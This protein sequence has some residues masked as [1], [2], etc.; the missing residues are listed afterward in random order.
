MSERF[1]QSEEVRHDQG[2]APAEHHVG[3]AVA[4]N[5]VGETQRFRGVKLVRKPFSRRRF[6]AAMQTAEIAIT[7]YLAGYEQESSQSVYPVLHATCHQRCDKM[8]QINKPTATR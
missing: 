7:G 4:D 2:L 6:G 8:P 1:G 5:L 3:H